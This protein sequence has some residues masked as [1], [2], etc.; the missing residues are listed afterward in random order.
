MLTNSE[1]RDPRTGNYTPQGYIDIS[2][3]I[4]PQ[5]LADERANG[6][7]RNEPIMYPVLPDPKYKHALLL[8][9]NLEIKPIFSFLSKI[10]FCS[11]K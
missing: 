1:W 2:V 3:K 11:L 9:I 8:L 4:L 7:W 6:F 10:N 5:K